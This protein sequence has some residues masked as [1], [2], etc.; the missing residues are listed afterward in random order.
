MSDAARHWI[1]P[2]GLL[3]LTLSIFKLTTFAHAGE[4]FA[5]FLIFVVIATAASDDGALAR[6][7]RILTSLNR[8]LRQPPPHLPQQST[9]GPIAV[10]FA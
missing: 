3:C 10:D 1:A 2:I 7:I 6:K 8:P 9:V 5:S 4:N